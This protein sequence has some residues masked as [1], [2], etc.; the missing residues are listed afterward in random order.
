MRVTKI[1]KEIEFEGI[2]GEGGVRRKEL[3][4][5]TSIHKIF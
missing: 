2:W 1:V 3:F 5:E 4:S